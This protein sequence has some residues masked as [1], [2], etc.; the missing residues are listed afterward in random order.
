[1]TRQ[2]WTALVAAVCFVVLA[3]LTAVVP[4][5]YVTRSPGGTKDT[6]GMAGSEPIISVRDIATFPTSGRLDLTIVSVTAAGSRLTLPQAVLAYFLP[7]RDA[8]PRDAVY[9]PG[10]T[11]DQVQREETDMMQTAQ[12]AAVVAALRAAGEP[13]QELPAVASVT[14]GGPASGKLRPGDLVVS[15]DGRPVRTAEAVGQRIRARRIGDPV[16]FV[17]LRDRVR[18]A[19]TVRTVPSTTQPG[20]PMVGITVDT[21]YRYGPRISFDVGQQIGGPSAGLVFAVAI[22]DKI[23]R[24]ALL[25]G[26]HVA[27]TGTIAADGRVGRIGGLQQKVVAAEDAG[28]TVFLLPGANCTDLAGLRTDLT[29]IRVGTLDE[30]LTALRTLER[31][32]DPA[33]LPAC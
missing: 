21:G 8:L 18:T 19:V 20:S 26:R 23:T 12:D 28:A 3:V 17:V 6:L 29:L 7:G 11:A 16:A 15:V 4:V 9:P 32:A 25:G 5:P 22:Y 30:A 10:K 2:T 33:A 1:M 27:G 13:V 24:G 31:G 14:V